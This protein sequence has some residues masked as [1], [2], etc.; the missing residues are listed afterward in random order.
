M[1]RY[2]EELFRIVNGTSGTDGSPH[3]FSQAY[4]HTL[5]GRT[6]LRLAPLSPWLSMAR[7]AAIGYG[8]LSTV[9]WAALLFPFVRVFGG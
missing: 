6:D 1:R 4:Q 9:V 7:F 8:V 2:R 3:A 5:A